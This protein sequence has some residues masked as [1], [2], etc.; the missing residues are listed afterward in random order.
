M[1]QQ[2]QRSEAESQSWRQQREQYTSSMPG[3][4]P[5]RSDNETRKRE[6]ASRQRELDLAF[7]GMSISSSSDNARRQIQ[8]A[9]TG[10]SVSRTSDVE[11]RRLDDAHRLQQWRRQED[12]RH[13]EEAMRHNMEPK[14]MPQEDRWSRGQE[15]GRSTAISVS[16][17]S[18]SSYQSTPS[19]PPVPTPVRAPQASRPLSFLGTYPQAMPL[20]SPGR[21]DGDSTDSESVSNSLGWKTRTGKS[22]GDSAGTTPRTPARRQAPPISVLHSIAY[23]GSLQSNVPT[24]HHHHLTSPS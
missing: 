10:Q 16:A 7:G 17:T 14:R 12:I 3:P 2:Q 6:E 13:G 4:S 15:S 23:I 22:R 8:G 20:E 19:G 5:S 24:T 21:Y 18:P 1:Q 11:Q 9:S